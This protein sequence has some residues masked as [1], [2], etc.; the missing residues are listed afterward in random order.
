MK[1]YIKLSYQC[2]VSDW[3]V[4]C[5]GLPGLKGPSKKWTVGTLNSRLLNT[6]APRCAPR[7]KG[8]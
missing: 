1:R 8:V 3:I 2:T 5:E 6:R 4:V 7:G